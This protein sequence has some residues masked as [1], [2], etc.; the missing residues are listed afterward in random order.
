MFCFLFC[1]WQETDLHHLIYTSKCCKPTFL[2]VNRSSNIADMLIFQL[3]YIII[4]KISHREPV[5]LII[6]EIKSPRIKVDLLYL[7]YSTRAERILVSSNEYLQ[8]NVA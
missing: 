6:S 3:I 2:A 8:A 5:N 7:F 1:K 4:V